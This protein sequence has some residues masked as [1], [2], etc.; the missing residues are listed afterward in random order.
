MSMTAEEYNLNIHFDELQRRAAFKSSAPRKRKQKNSNSMRKKRKAGPLATK[1]ERG[2]LQSDDLASGEATSRL[3]LNQSNLAS[4][5]PTPR[6]PHKSQCVAEE[7]SPKIH[8][9]S[10]H[11][12]VNMIIP[13]IN[14]AKIVC[15]RLQA[16]AEEQSYDENQISMLQILAETAADVK[17]TMALSLLGS[18]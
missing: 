11:E 9:D 8:G 10:L 1:D 6:F 16:T 13:D 2:S 4:I 7:G 15:T 3:K 14:I 17:D 12:M 18:I 5:A